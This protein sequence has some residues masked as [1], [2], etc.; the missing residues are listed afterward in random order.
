MLTNT[1]FDW[2]TGDL[3][4]DLPY[5]EIK[6]NVDRLKEQ[7]DTCE[8]SIETDDN[9]LNKWQEEVKQ[10][11]E[12]SSYDVWKRPPKREEIEKAI[13]HAQEKIAKWTDIKNKDEQK[14][15]MLH[16]TLVKYQEQ[17]LIAQN[18]QESFKS[19]NP[20]LVEI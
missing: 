16:D 1:M 9:N 12:W 10:L 8:E 2:V 14:K 18:V 7:L 11:N 5:S 3:L 15:R 13:A 6:K 4:L 20:Y 19:S 17:A